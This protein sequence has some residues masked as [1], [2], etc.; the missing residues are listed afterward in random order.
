MSIR[1]AS[2]V[3]YSLLAGFVVVVT[4]AFNLTAT[5]WI[6]FGIACA[7]TVAGAALMIPR[8]WAHRALNAGIM[9][10][11]VLLIIESL[12]AVGTALT[13]LSFAGA[14]GVLALALAGLTTHELTTERVVHS[15]EAPTPERRERAPM[16]A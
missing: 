15:L 9:I 1:Y 14:L 16:A 10:L 3:L 6:T 7:F 5:G 11:G 12:L 13:W 4:Q 2:N 8:G